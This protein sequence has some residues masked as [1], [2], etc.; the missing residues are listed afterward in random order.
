MAVSADVDPVSEFTGEAPMIANMMLT[1]SSREVRFMYYP[2][3]N[4]GGE[5]KPSS[6]LTNLLKA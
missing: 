3:K 1:A 4:R 6:P 5:Y 2:A